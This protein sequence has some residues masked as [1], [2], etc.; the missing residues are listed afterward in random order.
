MFIIKYR[1]YFFAL[2]ALLVGL[3]VWAML[4]YGFNFGIDF[5]GG[6][7]TEVRFD[8]EPLTDEGVQ[9]GG[10]PPKEI[11]EGRIQALDLGGFSVR[12]SGENSY[13]IR[14]R[15]LSTEDRAELEKALSVSHSAFT[16]ERANTIGPLAGADLTRK[17]VIAVSVVV[18]FILLFIAYAFRKVSVADESGKESDLPSSWKY[19]L[20]TIISLF[21]DVI[22]ATGIF[23]FLGHLYG[24][25]IDL[26]FVTGILAILGY[27]VHDS[28]VVFDRVRE[29]LILNQVKKR[30]EEF[31]T[32]VGQ[33][34]Q[35]TYGRS[36]NTSITLLI[37][38]LALYFLGS[39][40]TKDFSLLLA[41][42][43]LIGAYSSV[44]LASPLLV[45][46]YKMAKK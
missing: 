30:K 13:I 35:Q 41:L 12:P 34:L 3:S 11:I 15:E 22:V 39:S 37:T 9:P 19:G 18:M 28:I 26:L 43:A 42:G 45:T 33:A 36:I 29:N 4:A 14:T 40:A 32:T 2:S 8:A 31:E 10:R 6:S 38:L 25:E 5:K 16:I 20:A 23:V 17:S 21:H 44:F 46:F 24:V 27:S 7:I 1:K